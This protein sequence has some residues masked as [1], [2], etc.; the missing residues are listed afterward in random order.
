MAQTESKMLSL[1][2]K[3]PEFNLPNVVNGSNHSFSE[4]QGR[5]GTLL[6]F[7]CN[8][9]PYVIH[10]IEALAAFAKDIEPQGISTIAI[11]SNSVVTHP[12]DGPEA[13][14]TFAE[15]FNFSFPYLYDATQEVAKS[16]DAACTPDLYLF[17]QKGE[18]FYRGRFD[19]S[20]PGNDLPL[21]GSDLKTAVEFL[22]KGE[23]PP[24]KQ[25]PSLGCNIKWHPEN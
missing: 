19:T 2:T 17:D 10:I 18:L 8:H 16:Y 21:S 14:K 24:E 11:S 23:K 5:Q 15:K 13:M 4:L 25:Y 6:V 9:C 20:R 22:L 12:Q 1:K 3:A 7:M